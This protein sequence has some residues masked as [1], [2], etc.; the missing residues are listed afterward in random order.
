MGQ[1][2]NIDILREKIS[3]IDTPFLEVSN[4]LFAG[5]ADVHTGAIAADGSSNHGITGC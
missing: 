3:L 4:N 1:R 2:I 5:G